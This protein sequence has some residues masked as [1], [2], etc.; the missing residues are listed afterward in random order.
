MFALLLDN[1]MRLRV[2]PIAED[3]VVIVANYK[4]GTYMCKYQIGA[5]DTGSNE[6]NTEDKIGKCQCGNHDVFFPDS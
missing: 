6:S 4:Y 1:P 3:N 5:I 2:R